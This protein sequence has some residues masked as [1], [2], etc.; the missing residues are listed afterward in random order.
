MALAL[1]KKVFLCLSTKEEFSLENIVAFYELEDVTHLIG[2]L[3]ENVT[4]IV[5]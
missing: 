2:T 1:K 4:A 5:E 3:E